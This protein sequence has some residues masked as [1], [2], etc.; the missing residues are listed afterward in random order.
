MLENYA[1]LGIHF[2]REI[3]NTNHKDQKNV[4]LLSSYTYKALAL[5]SVGKSATQPFLVSSRNALPH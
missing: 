3:L 1:T 5:P 4:R 2:S